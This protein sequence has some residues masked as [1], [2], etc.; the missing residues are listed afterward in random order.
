VR[1]LHFLVDGV[2]FKPYAAHF[3]AGAQQC[4]VDQISVEVSKMNTVPSLLWQE[5]QTVPP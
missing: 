3:E 5:E 1:T 4:G 2:K